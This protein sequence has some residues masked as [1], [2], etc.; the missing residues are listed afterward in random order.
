MSCKCC[1][2]LSLNYANSSC[3]MRRRKNFPIFSFSRQYIFANKCL[4]TMHVGEFSLRLSSCY[5]NFPSTL[6]RCSWIIN[7]WFYNWI[8]I[9]GIMRK[10]FHFLDDG[11]EWIIGLR[12]TDSG[13]V[14][15]EV[16]RSWW[17]RLNMKKLNIELRWWC[18]HSG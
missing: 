10:G 14:V 1:H 3:G 12:M 8:N 6:W 13:L 15:C 17:M 16:I 2:C 5:E 18:F 4:K 11:M 9:S 7:C